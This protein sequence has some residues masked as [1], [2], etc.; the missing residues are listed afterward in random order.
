MQTT[1]VG[2]VEYVQLAYEFRPETENGNS[3]L[4]HRLFLGST[5]I[6]RIDLGFNAGDVDIS[7]SASG[8]AI[9]SA[10]SATTLINNEFSAIELLVPTSLITSD[11]M[12]LSIQ[13][14]NNSGSV[15]PRQN[16]SI[17]DIQFV[18]DTDQ[19]GIYNHLDIDADNDGITDN[20]E[21]QS[22]ANYIA[23]SGIGGT[24][25]WLDVNSDGL[26]DRYDDTQA[27]VGQNSDGSYIHTGIGLNPVDTDSDAEVD[28]LDLDSDNDGREDAAERG[29]A[30]SVTAQTGVLSDSITDADG[31]GLLDVF[32]ASDTTDG[33]DV[34]DENLNAVNEFTLT[35][36][37]QNVAADGSDS[38][39]GVNDFDWR[40]DQAPKIDLNTSATAV[41]V[42][43][44]F[45]STFTEGGGA[46]N[47]ADAVAG[48]T[49][50]GENDLL[51]LSIAVGFV[52]DGADEIVSVNGVSI[53]LNANAANSNT[54]IAGV[55]VSIN[56]DAATGVITLAATDGMTVFTEADICLLYT[57]PSPRDRG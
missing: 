38:V 2:G 33:F 43:V 29:T 17:T 42:D 1:E 50:F 26:D 55:P 10:N 8:G 25:A 23:P 56:Y 54:L 20:V 5:E 19:D 41:D 7:N 31:D 14:V 22:T 36:S 15:P 32:E 48:T 39:V 24:A 28:Y 27:G 4:I 11:T 37:N 13:V 46:I 52:F 16:Y 35:D 34:N 40:E 21:A 9:L 30:G 53:P 57:S 18:V 3:N 47:V 49:S 51:E 45:T 12:N 44:D 6:Q